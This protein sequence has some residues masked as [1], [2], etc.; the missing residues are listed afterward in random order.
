MADPERG[1]LLFEE[2]ADVARLT[3]FVQADSLR[4]TIWKQVGGNGSKTHLLSRD[5][6]SPSRSAGHRYSR[7]DLMQLGFP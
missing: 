2:L 4:E 3:H 7:S 6:T 5:L 1:V